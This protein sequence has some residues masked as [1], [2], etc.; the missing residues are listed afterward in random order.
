MFDDVLVDRLDQRIVGDGLDE[1]RAVV[2]LGRGGHVDLQGEAP[3]L[4]QHA[5]MD[6]LDGLEP[7]HARVVDVV[8]LVIE[9]GEFVDLA[10][11]LAEVGFAV[12]GLADGLGA[13]GVVR[14]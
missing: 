5:V 7:G 14:K 2:V 1:D 12:G 11:D 13:E 3:V 10:D 6:V 9:H 4:L 8:G